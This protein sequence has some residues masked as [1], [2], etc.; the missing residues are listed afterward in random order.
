ML[1]AIFANTLLDCASVS[2][3]VYIMKKGLLYYLSVCMYVWSV[4]YGHSSFSNLC[5]FY[6]Q[7]LLGWTIL[8]YLSI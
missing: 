6:D 2:T 3:L 1:S 4:S 8:F 7:F 5:I